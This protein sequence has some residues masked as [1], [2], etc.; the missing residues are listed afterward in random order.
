MSERA[1]PDPEQLLAQAGWL[2]RL[3]RGLVQDAHAADDLVQDA[4]VAALENGPE[5]PRALAPW[6]AQVTRNLAHRRVRA[7]AHR[8]LREERGAKPEGVP[9]QSEVSERVALQRELLE[10]VLALDEPYRSTLLERYFEERSPAEIARRAEIPVRTVKTR[11]ARGLAQLREKLERKHTHDRDVFALALVGFARGHAPL[12]STLIG[13]MLVN[14]KLATASAVVLAALLG[15]YWWHAENSALATTALGPGSH[16]LANEPAASTPVE[17]ATVAARTT[18]PP[19]ASPGATVPIDDPRALRGI[20]VD[21]RHVPIPGAQIEVLRTP[22]AHDVTTPAP[23]DV[24]THIATLASDAAGRFRVPLERG[25][26]FD[27]VVHARGFASLLDPGHYAGDEL[28]VVLGSPA[29]LEGHVKRRSDGGACA[30]ARVRCRAARPELPGPIQSETQ[31]DAEGRFEF[32][33]L[34][35]GGVSLSILPLDAQVLYGSS[36]EIPEGGSVSR[37]FLVEPGIDVEGSVLDDASGEAVAGASIEPWFRGLG[38]STT[39]DSSGRF[40]LHGLGDD[41]RPARVRLQVHADGYANEKVELPAPIQGAMRVEVRLRSGVHVRGSLVDSEGRPVAGARV[42]AVGHGVV[43]DARRFDSMSARSDAQGRFE[44]QGLR[45]DLAWILRIDADGCARRALAFPEPPI[46]GTCVDFGEIALGAPALLHGRLVDTDGHGIEGFYVCL[47]TN[48]LDAGPYPSDAGADAQ[49]LKDQVRTDAHG[50]FALAGLRGGSY[51]IWAGRKG[52]ARA[53]E[54]E[55][56]VEASSESE[57]LVLTLDLG[58]SISGVLLGPEGKPVAGTFLTFYPAG[59]D[60]NRVSYLFT[61]LDGSFLMNGLAEGEYTIV[62]EPEPI[63]PGERAETAPNR[64]EHVHS[65]A[66]DLQLALPPSDPIEGHVTLPDGAKGAGCVVSGRRAGES[67]E[68]WAEFE[69]L[70]DDEGRFHLRVPRGLRVD[71]SARGN[72]LV[73]DANG[74]Y[75]R[76]EATGIA[77]GTKNLELKL[78][79]RP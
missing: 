42:A 50:R 34:P 17:S 43:A 59:D 60:L 12:Y 1:R 13:G 5:E 21:T 57:E 24:R 2:R 9:A 15:I 35:P 78:V 65:G 45:R 37:E 55:I 28:V 36:V 58:S 56:Q 44:L 66:R 68:G 73:L 22:G 33:D 29:T 53:V 54:R 25:L 61:G 75:D 11:L 18:T 19:P 4:W 41:G 77:A 48:R 74:S 14:W 20:V 30:D 16:E 67:S 39:S 27:L 7:E 76:A 49:D 64:W 6:L 72:P 70:A 8:K 51:W 71:L 23:D 40:V 69:T 62:A 31:T 63:E 3:A 79:H 10:L 46:Q 52:C 38:H 32:H 26:N 47:N